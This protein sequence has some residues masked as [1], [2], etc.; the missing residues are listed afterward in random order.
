L[1]PWLRDARTTITFDQGPD[2]VPSVPRL[3]ADNASP[4]ED[5]S[6]ATTRIM[7]RPHDP[8]T[9]EEIEKREVVK[10]YEYSPRPI[11][12]LHRRGDEGA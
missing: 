3:L 6:P 8:V 9:G 7:L 10:G 4:D 1:A 11:S 2:T 12:H 5:Q